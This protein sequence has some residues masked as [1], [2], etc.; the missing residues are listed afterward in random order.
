MLS[1]EFVLALLQA[2]ITGAGL[3]LASY[4]LFTPM[5]RKFFELR[6]KTMYERLSELKKMT[7]EKG[8][9]I[10]KEGIEELKGLVEDLETFQS[11]PSWL[12][13]GM[14]GSFVGYVVST[15]LAVGWVLDFEGNRPSFDSSLSPIFVCSTIVFLFTGFYIIKEMNETM[16]EEFEE[17]KKK[18][19]EARLGTKPSVET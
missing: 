8:V 13:L 3:V 1:Q 5:A 9:R 15:L 10:T 11:M 18:I 7:S 16:K 12:T 17:L 4:T 14:Y 6:A 2:S 19:E